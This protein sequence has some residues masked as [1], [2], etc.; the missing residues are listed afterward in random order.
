MGGDPMEMMVMMMVEQAKMTDEQF[1]ST[2]V[3][4]HEFEDSLMYFC[5]S[6]QEVKMAMQM[7]MMEMQ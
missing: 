1:K 3:E 7:Y 4:Q 6:D 5:Q 2:G